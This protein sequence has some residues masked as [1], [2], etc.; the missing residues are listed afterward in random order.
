VKT[1]DPRSLHRNAACAA[2]LAALCAGCAS[3]AK[4]EMEAGVPLNTAITP[5]AEAIESG[6]EE[7][8]QA[9]VINFDSPSE[10]LSSYIIEELS[11]LLVAGKKI[12]VVERKDLDLVRGELSFQYSGEAS[13]ESMRSLGRMLGAE[14]I[15]SGSI[16]KAGAV[17]KFRVN[18]VNVETAVREAAVS[19]NVNDDSLIASLLDRPPGVRP[20]EP[21][22]ADITLRLF[23][24][25]KEV[26]PALVDRD[27]GNAVP[28]YVLQNKPFTIAFPDA[29]AVFVSASTRW[30]FS[31]G[32]RFMVAWGDKDGYPYFVDSV[33]CFRRGAGR[34]GHRAFYDSRLYVDYQFDAYQWYESG[35][36]VEVRELF[37]SG[38]P[39]LK[40]IEGG[41]DT[42]YA[43]LWTNK[44][45]DNY[46][47]ADEV[48]FIEL[49]V[50]G[51]GS[52]LTS[53]RK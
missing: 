2:L 13:D 44:N 26:K 38:A 41:Q 21:S 14:V 1:S 18:A 50:R 20:A 27:F 33:P 28:S 24:N 51:K 23:Q 52:L 32:A 45:Q 16:V 46:V 8:T 49:Q 36:R 17:Y 4:A 35:S 22:G 9:A 6:L 48:L 3:G 19:E 34:E 39:A 42:V 25:N 53:G 37:V 47:D 43:A 10:A 11:F 15:V 31:D 30:F 12:T 29:G 5:A 40:A 7:G